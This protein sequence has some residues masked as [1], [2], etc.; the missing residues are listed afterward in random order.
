VTARAL[1]VLATFALAAI[2]GAVF[3]KPRARLLVDGQEAAPRCPDGDE[4]RERVATRL[5]YRALRDDAG[6]TLMVRYGAAEAGALSA[7]LSAFDE[8]GRASGERTLRASGPDCDE[9]AESIV[10]T[11]SVFL[12]AVPSAPPR[13]ADVNAGASAVGTDALARDVTPVATL[14][15]AASER[16]TFR[17]R[18]AMTGAF[19]VA[20][21]FAPGLSAALGFR[22]GAWTLEGEGRFDA[23]ASAAF[24]EGGVRTQLRIGELVACRRF[25]AF[26]VCPTLGL[27]SMVMEGVDLPGARRRTRFVSMAGLRGSLEVPIA[28]GIFLTAHAEAAALLTP[29]I[30]AV[31]ENDVWST[32]PLAAL[33]ALGLGYALP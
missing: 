15:D 4:L 13:S 30:V 31:G 32:P 22:R 21:S 25:H 28:H 2:P 26:G 14:S 3:A 11:L 12:E 19:G 6:W 17:G 7:T 20:P 23:P 8:R 18:A 10:L 27:G 9:L 16:T 5:G 29:T 24:G 1:A 33:G